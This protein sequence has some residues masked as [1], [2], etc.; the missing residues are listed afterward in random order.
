LIVLAGGLLGISFPPLNIF[1]GSFFGL[2]LIIHLTLDSK[3]YKQ[4]F[5]RSY[6]IFIVE[7]LIAISWISLSGLQK[8]ADTFLAIS[9]A[10]MIII[11]S[12][13]LL[14]PVLIFFFISRNIKIKKFPN[15]VL[16]F[17]PFTWVA[18]EYFH[19]LGEVSFPWLTI[20]NAFSTQLNKI[21]FIE[22]TGVFGISFWACIIAALIY[23]LVLETRRIDSK[24]FIPAFTK[25][26]N[27]YIYIV[28]LLLYILPDIYSTATSSRDK[29]T[30]YK[31]EGVL[32]IGVIQP[33]YNPWI[34][35]TTN[36]KAMTEDYAEMIKDLTAN[37]KNLDLIVLPEAALNYYLLDSNNESKF[38]IL[39]NLVDSLNIPVLTG[40]PDIKIW[41]D[42]LNAP[43]DAPKY[44]SIYKYSSYNSAILIEKNKNNSE[45]QKYHKIHLVAGSER[46]PHQ[47]QLSFLKDFIKWEVGI[48][49][50]EIGTDTTIFSLNGKGTF[51]TAICYESVYPDFFRRFVNKGA[52]FS[53]VITN[54]GWWGKLFG[55]YQHNQF[56]ILRAV[57][58]RR[59]IVRSANTGISCIIDPYGN[60]TNKTE[61]YERAMFAS[62][63]GINK[64][65]TFYTEHGDLIG[66][67]SIYLTSLLIFTGLVFKLYNSVSKRKL[68]QQ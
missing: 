64:E 67:I 52:D 20:G 32:K 17:F 27:I 46:L 12:L 66:E 33:N 57:E 62:D 29:Y 65:T 1:F 39:K 45:L 44:N 60:M 31:K 14:I 41:T 9:G 24:S 8:H 11:H 53:V 23:Y 43:K 42:T 58:N 54:D 2:A 25:R 10:I 28:L 35:W 36:S 50:Y 55:T 4:F 47:D 51:N 61:I 21:Q 37:N 40:A 3:N 68:K 56:A 26:K 63:I 19:S 5:L 59:W 30:E 34:K 7:Q 13:F 15:F 48:S 6:L 49:S 16:I 18:F 38:R 22:I